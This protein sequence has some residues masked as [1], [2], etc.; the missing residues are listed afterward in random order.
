MKREDRK[1]GE[2]EDR[3][4]PE[5]EASKFDCAKSAVSTRWVVPLSV[6]ERLERERDEA[7]AHLGA[8]TGHD[9]VICGR[10]IFGAFIGSGNGFGQQF[11]HPACYYRRECGEAREAAAEWKGVAEMMSADITRFFAQQFGRL[12]EPML[13]GELLATYRERAAAATAKESAS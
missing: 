2:R 11:A 3:L 6:A 7:L 1:A 8:K 12:A 13:G 10:A 5:T 4:T 9:C